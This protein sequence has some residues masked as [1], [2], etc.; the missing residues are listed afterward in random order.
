MTTT[1]STPRYV[2]GTTQEGRVFLFT[3]LGEYKSG[4]AA[5]DAALTMPRNGVWYVFEERDL[6]RHGVVFGLKREIVATVPAR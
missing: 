3:G 2:L 1:Q 4:M 6:S 5:R